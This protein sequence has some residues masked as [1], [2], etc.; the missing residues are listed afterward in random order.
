MEFWPR[1]LTGKNKRKATTTKKK[2]IMKKPIIYLNM[3]SPYG[4][5]TVDEFQREDGQDPKGFRQYVRDMVR[6]YHT[7]GQPV[8]KSSRST[9]EWAQR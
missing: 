4:V 5:E 2:E 8:Y 1:T 3:R 6:E 7:T 9:K